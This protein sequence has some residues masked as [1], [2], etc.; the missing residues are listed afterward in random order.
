MWYEAM[1]D[2]RPEAIETNLSNKYVYIRRNVRE[3]TRED[4]M[5]G[6]K[7]FYVFEETKV[8]KDVYEMLA[9]QNARLDDIEEAIAEIVGG[10][11]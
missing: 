11:F 8:P 1:S 3:E 6:S 9:P 7:T 5:E 10:G 2:D 4:E